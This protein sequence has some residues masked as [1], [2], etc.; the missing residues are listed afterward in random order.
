[1]QSDIAVFTSQAI[2]GIQQARIFASRTSRSVIRGDDLLL[3]ICTL[4]Q[5]A[6]V[7]DLRE[8]LLQVPHEAFWNPWVQQFYKLD[9]STFRISTDS[10]LPLSH[11]LNQE[12]AKLIRQ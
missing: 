3:G 11:K 4:L 9:T 1:M 10:D 7:L 8:M 12:I 6:D 5:E 2:S